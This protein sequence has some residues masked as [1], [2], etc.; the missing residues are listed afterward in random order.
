MIKMNIRSYV[1]ALA[2]V[3]SESHRGDCPKCRGKGTFTAMN[4]GGTMKYNCYKLGCVVGGIYESDMSASEIM[5]RIRPPPSKAVEEIETME[6]PA[7][8]VQPTLEHPK[9]NKFVMRWGI[10]A[11]PGLMYD[12]KQERVVFPIHHR[13]RLIDAVGR[14]VG[15]RMQPKWYRYTGDADYFTAGSGD[16]VLLVEDVVS[17]VVASQLMPD[18]TALAIL[19][20]S[21]SDKHMAKVSS[22]R[23]VVIALDP[24]AMDKT[25]EFRR[26]IELWTGIE[27]VAMKLHDDIKYKVPEDIKQLKDICK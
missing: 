11:Y 14:A 7:Y 17:A 21:L 27:T 3:D 22:Y 9:H 23:K 8:L 1:E 20:T 25:L 4:D 13:G 10:R 26:A 5:K 18:I 12:V 15:T 24:D 6:I 2:L 19:G 16:V